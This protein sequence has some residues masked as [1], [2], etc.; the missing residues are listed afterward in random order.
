VKK[1]L[2]S[3]C[4]ITYNHERYIREAVDSILMQQTDFDWQL[5]IADDCSTDRTRAILQEYQRQHPDNIH[6]LLQP[7]NVGPE[8]NWLDLISYPHTRYVLYMEGDDYLTDTTKL[9]RQVDFLESHPDYALCFHPVRVVYEGIDRPDEV[10]PE[11]ARFVRKK[12]ITT[13]MLLGG[14]FIQTDSVMYRWQFT[15]W[16]VRD[17][18]PAGMIPG[19]WY[20]HLLHARAG[21]I[22]FINR[23]MAVYRR[24]SEGIWW[25]SANNVDEIWKRYG[26]GHLRFYAA[27]LAL[28][29][30]DAA[31]RAIVWPAVYRMLDAFVRIDAAEGTSLL[32]DAAQA[33]P[34]AIAHYAAHT[35][36]VLLHTQQALHKQER[37]TAKQL[38]KT[39]SLEW[40]YQ[41]VVAQKEQQLAAI[42]SSKLWRLRTEVAKRIGRQP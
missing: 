35:Q 15:D 19:D 22:G 41:A 37:A 30:D 31:R 33:V 29:A 28:Y 5:I 23:V 14:N 39:Q 40:H 32:A 27:V 8:Q 38:Q 11:P 6:L 12:H 17:A 26:M 4:I 9:Q 36:Q 21:K 13:D 34:E 42:T 1:P 25:E 10:F 24:H 2:L 16:P 7:K 18:F 20:L 3:I